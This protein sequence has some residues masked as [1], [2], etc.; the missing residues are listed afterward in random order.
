MQGPQVEA[1]S[2]QGPRGRAVSSGPAAPGILVRVD[3]YPQAAG[4]RHRG[5]SLDIVVVRLVVRSGAARLEPFPSDDEPDHAET[6]ALEP[7]QVIRGLGFRQGASDEAR[8]APVIQ[9][10]RGLQG[11]PRPVR[12]LAVTAQVAAT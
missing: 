12:R 4:R 2:L 9:L 6:P 7:V 5:D 3:E 1:D 10:G 8:L 11:I